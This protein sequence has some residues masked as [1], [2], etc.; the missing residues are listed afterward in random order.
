MEECWS[1]LMCCFLPLLLLVHSSQSG[2]Q[3]RMKMSLF[4]QKQASMS[5]LLTE[6][7]AFTNESNS[8]LMNHVTTVMTALKD[9]QPLSSGIRGKQLLPG[10]TPA[11]LSCQVL[12]KILFQYIRS[13]RDTQRAAKRLIEVCRLLVFNQRGICEGLINGER[14]VLEYVIR[15]GHASPVQLC[16]LIF[17]SRSVST[18]LHCNLQFQGDEWAVHIPPSIPGRGAKQ[19]SVNESD[20][21]HVMAERGVCLPSFGR[22][23]KTQLLHCEVFLAQIKS[24]SKV[25]AMSALSV[26][27]AASA[28]LPDVHVRGKRLGRQ[29]DL[30]GGRPYMKMLHLTDLHYDPKYQAGSNAECGAPVCCQVDSGIPRNPAAAAGKWGDY[31]SCDSPERLV[32]HMLDHIRSNHPDIDYILYTGDSVPHDLWR[33]NKE[34][35]SAV[36]NRVEK[37]LSEYFPNTPIFGALG[38]HESFPRDS[39]PPPEDLTV[40]RKFNNLWLYNLMADHWQHHLPNANISKE[41][42]IT[43]SYSALL[44]PGFRIISVNTNFC[45]KLNWWV[46]YKN[47]DPGNVLRWLVQELLQA[48][49]R[50]ERVQI[51]AHIA[52]LYGDCYEQW[53]HQFSRVVTR[54]SKT[55]RGQFYGHSH[56]MEVLLHYD[57]DN[58]N[59]PVGVQYLTPSNTPYS[60]LNPSYTLFYIDGN[61]PESTRAVLDKEIFFMNLTAANSQDDVR[62]LPLYSIKKDLNL[63]SLEAI[64]W[65]GFVRRMDKDPEL[66]RKFHQYQVV[67]SDV[68]KDDCDRDCRKQIICSM[69]DGD[70]F[71]PRKCSNKT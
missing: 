9:G 58:P 23:M 21:K 43:G 31:R 59:R 55:I 62:W 10:V 39:F 6:I 24:R 61:H 25:S 4:D 52:P 8:N 22:D 14:P 35:N 34:K 70:S 1:A 28:L 27:D 42:R 67:A 26:S 48:E 12:A 30:N 17:S 37:L 15:R 49:Q 33:L 2:P 32:L 13:N 71:L 66:T 5:D 63:N 44:E 65:E 19:L 7:R 29:N 16:E 38:N 47:T 11:C 57:V 50:G 3:D 36:I 40:D 56:L 41:A 18:D 53:R 20:P 64:D 68:Q 60:R 45:N 51:I 54:F 69:V 46:L